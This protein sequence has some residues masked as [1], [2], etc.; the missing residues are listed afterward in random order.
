M[1]AVNAD[2]EA[3]PQAK[4]LTVLVPTVKLPLINVWP[5][6]LEENK[7][8]LNWQYPEGIADLAGFQVYQNNQLVARPAAISPDARQWVSPPLQPGKYEFRIQAITQSG[9]TSTQSAPKTFT[10]K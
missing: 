7:V 10:I 9:L 1:I 3:G 6:A 2:N 5:V 8:T 4:A